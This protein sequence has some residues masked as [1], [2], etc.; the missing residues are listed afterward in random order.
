MPVVAAPWGPRTAG[1]VLV[2]GSPTV[3]RRLDDHVHPEAVSFPQEPEQD[4]LRTDV[5]VLEQAR[6]LLRQDDN[7]SRTVREPLEHAASFP[8]P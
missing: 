3:R 1:P 8:P 7:S 2:R 5:V 4:V 6:F